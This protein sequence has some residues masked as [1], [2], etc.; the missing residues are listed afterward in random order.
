MRSHFAA[1][2][3]PHFLGFPDQLYLRVATDVADVEMSVVDPCESD[4]G[5]GGQPLGVDR[6]VF[7]F[8]PR[9]EV[10]H[11]DRQRGHPE[12]TVR[13]VEVHLQTSYVRAGYRVGGVVRGGPHVEGE[14]TAGLTGG[15]GE[16]LGQA[17]LVHH[18]RGVVWH[19]HHADETAGQRGRGAG[20]EVFL[21]GPSGI[22]QV[23]VGINQPRQLHRRHISSPALLILAVWGSGKPTRIQPWEASA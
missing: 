2:P 20:G 8:R 17:R 3:R 6:D 1:N 19:S 13:L 4:G 11:E 12:G 18:R 7:V 15:N 14:V 10:S 23:Y 22:P 16:F 9:T 5:G 21:V